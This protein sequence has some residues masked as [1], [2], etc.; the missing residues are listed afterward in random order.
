MK[1]ERWTCDRCEGK[2]P[3]EPL[4]YAGIIGPPLIEGG[5]PH[6]TTRVHLCEGC[7][8]AVVAFM[9]GP[10]LRKHLETPRQLNAYSRYE[11]EV[12]WTVRVRFKDA[13]A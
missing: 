6:M 11:P 2:L 10:S 8:N 9:V 3:G 12:P 4:V 13:D 5:G 1:S 7:M